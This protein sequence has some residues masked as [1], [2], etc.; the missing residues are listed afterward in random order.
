MMFTVAAI[1][2]L[3][4]LA[5]AITRGILGPTVFDRALAANAVGS[6][7]IMLLAVVLMALVYR[8]AR[9]LFGPWGGVLSLVA[10]AWDPAMIAHS[11]LGTTD[12]GVTLSAF[13][14]FYL[15]NRLLRRYSVGRLIGTGLLLGAALASKASGLTVVP[16]LALL[17]GQGCLREMIAL[18]RAFR[19]GQGGRGNWVCEPF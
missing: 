16:V 15:A 3:V 7:A 19:S 10:M 1:A 18:W 14:C 13:A 12:L 4:A 8:W 17:L 2:I 6:L 9:D 5:L 11:Q